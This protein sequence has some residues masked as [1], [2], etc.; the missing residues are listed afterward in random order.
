M[1]SKK[2]ETALNKQFNQELYNSNLYISMSAFFAGK[3]LKGYAHWMKIQAEEERMHAEKF[4]AFMMD[5]DCS[6]KVSAITGPPTTWRTP[7]AAC[8]A[9]LKAEQDNTARINELM[10]LAIKEKDHATR[11][12]LQWFIDEQVEE[13]ANASDLIEQTKMAEKAPGAMF[14]LDRELGQRPPPTAAE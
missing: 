9:A 13:E 11:G 5:R 8:Q 7:L 1:I 2:L 3:N 10:D 6:V 14:M 12:V 4:F